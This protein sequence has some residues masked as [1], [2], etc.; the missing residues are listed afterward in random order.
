[1]AVSPDS[2]SG[3]ALLDGT[4]NHA[5]RGLGA[6][7][8]GSVGTFSQ[9]QNRAILIVAVTAA[10]I[11]L[12][13]ALVSLRWFLSMKRSFRHHLILMLM[14]SDSFKAFWYF[15]SPVVIFS[16]HGQIESSSAFTQ[17]SGFL[18]AVG[19][20]AADLSI[21][22]IALH[23]T[24]YIFRPP[25]KLDNGGLH[26]YRYWAYGSWLLLPHL[27]ASLAFTNPSGH[28]YVTTGTF[29]YLPKRPFWYRLALAW[30]PR[31]I[32]FVSIIAMYAA[33]YVYVKVKFSGFD[34]LESG[35]LS[36][37]TD[38][39]QASRPGQKSNFT[40]LPSPQITLTSDME[41][42]QGYRRKSSSLAVSDSLVDHNYGRRQSAMPEG[43]PEWEKADF[44]T[45]PPSPSPR[46]I[47][48]LSVG[49][50]AADFAR[51][52]IEEG[53]GSRWGPNPFRHESQSTIRANGNDVVPPASDAQLTH[54][55]VGSAPSGP[56]RTATVGSIPTS[57]ASGATEQLT[58]TR[59]AI[60]RQLRFLFIYP[61]IYLLLWI[62]PFVQ[63]CLNYTDY[64]VAH[65]Q[66]WLSVCTTCLLALQAGVDC[67]VF[68]WRERPWRRMTGSP[69]LSVWAFRKLRA[70]FSA[71]HEHSDQDGEGEGEGDGVGSSDPEAGKLK[72]LKRDSDWWEEE[73][74]KRKDSVWLGTDT[75][76]DII[77]TQTRQSAKTP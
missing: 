2:Q 37:D 61:L 34:S 42:N 30:I 67:V 8:A 53:S 23:T 44:I 31:Y 20:E 35:D 49:V 21:F 47:S 33:I 75:V 41:N 52:G 57:R 65:P 43:I 51:D 48:Q 40:S 4:S 10:S 46:R 73:G 6:A 76:N 38:S 19:V 54:D 15:L 55:T 59:I 13:I 18:L 26:R 74:K 63:H 77:R 72:K 5:A 17:A 56:S 7:K 22:F 39:A 1:M 50:E 32:I 12:T 45:V 62:L 58:M 69:F 11:S 70:R 16:T 68:S 71:K 25:Q 24:L 29:A 64:Y 9:A 36:L 60:R 28:A 3:H 66:F 27:A 14:I